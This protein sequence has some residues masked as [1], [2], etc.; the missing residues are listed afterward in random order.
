[1]D[2]LLL[3]DKV[4]QYFQSFREIVSVDKGLQVLLLVIYC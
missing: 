4:G 1:M 2:F 3:D